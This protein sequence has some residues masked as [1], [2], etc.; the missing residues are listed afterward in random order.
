ML[1][2][3]GLNYFDQVFDLKFNDGTKHEDISKIYINLFCITCMLISFN[4]MISSLSLLVMGLLLMNKTMMVTF[5]S[6][7]FVPTLSST[8]ILHLK[9]KQQRQ[10]P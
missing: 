10:L 8:C 3:H 1:T 2:W 7:A 6:G 5:F 9:S 4:I